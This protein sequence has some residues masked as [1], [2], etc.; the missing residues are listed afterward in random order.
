[1]NFI[2]SF[3][4]KI[5]KKTN[6]KPTN[7]CAYTYMYTYPYTRTTYAPGT[8]THTSPLPSTAL[9]LSHVQT[10]S[11]LCPSPLAARLF[12]LDQFLRSYDTRKKRSARLPALP[13]RRPVCLFIFLSPW[14][15][16]Q[17]PRVPQHQGR[18]SSPRC[19]R[20]AGPWPAPPPGWPCLRVGRQ[21]PARGSMKA[22]TQT[23]SH[24]PTHPNNKITLQHEGIVSVTR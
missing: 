5:E 12:P 1:M 23:R 13:A 11:R 19:R 7:V 18:A 24:S 2:C 15:K 3:P 14:E 9:P 16:L 22:A 10:A 17:S 4:L 8:H 20:L 6:H 21:R